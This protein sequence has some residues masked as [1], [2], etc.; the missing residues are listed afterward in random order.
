MIK[1]IDP[2]LPGLSLNAV[3]FL[4]NEYRIRL[5]SLFL[6]HPKTVRSICLRGLTPLPFTT[7]PPPKYGPSG[8]YSYF[9]L[10]YP[11]VAN[12]YMYFKS[13]LYNN[14]IIAAQNYLVKQTLLF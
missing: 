12:M 1:L 7:P 4:I 13:Y 11:F 14:C 5:S 6:I 10:N 8:L 3:F 9:S 2:L